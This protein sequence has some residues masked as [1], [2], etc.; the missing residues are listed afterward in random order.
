MEVANA[1]AYYNT[2]TITVRKKFYSSNVQFERKL[3]T[4]LMIV[5]REKMNTTNTT[6]SYKVLENS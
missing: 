3:A 5:W 2:A 6:N 4:F 1:L